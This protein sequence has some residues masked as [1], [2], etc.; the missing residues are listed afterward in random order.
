MGIRHRHDQMGFWDRDVGYPAYVMDR[1]AYAHTLLGQG[2]SSWEPLSK[3]LEDVAE[4]AATYAIAF[5]G[6][7]WARILGGCHDLGK[8]SAAFQRYLRL[9]ADA[10]DAGVEGNAGAH[11]DHSTFG[12]R[13]V[14]NRVGGW[15]G[16]L[17]AFAIAGHH[18]GLPN[19]VSSDGANERSTL[20]SRLDP[21]NSIPDVD[22]LNLNLPTLT[23]PWPT[24]TP[25]RAAWSL[26][27]FTRMLFSCLVDADRTCTEAFCSPDSARDRAV[28]RPSLSEL[29][30]A[31]TAHLEKL[32]ASAPASPVNACRADVLRGCLEA[33]IREP[34]FFSLQVPTGGGKTLSSLAFA[35]RHANFHPGMRRVIIAIPFTSIIE[36]TADVYRLALGEFAE[37]ALVEHHTNIAPVRDTR[38]NQLGTENWDAPLIVTTNV[39]LLESLFAARTTACRKLH[40]IAGSVIILDEAQTIPVDLLTPTLA[41]LRE[42]VEHSRCSVVLCTATQPALEQRQEFPQ[43]LSG[44]RQIIPS[45][46]RLFLRLNRVELKHAGRLTDTELVERLVASPQVLCIVNTRRHASELFDRLVLEAS[47]SSLHLST[48]MCGAHRRSVLSKI[49]ERLDNGQLC[50]IIST[51][52]IEAGVDIDLPVVYRASAGFDSIA[53]AA[54]RCNREGRLAKG[55]IYVFDADRDP[56]PGTL[57]EGAQCARELWHRYP[58]PLSPDAIREYFQR[59]Y[60]GRRDRWDAKNILRMFSLDR[61]R[62]T[63]RFQFRDAEEAYRLIEDSSIPILIPFDER[64]TGFLRSLASGQV[65]FIPQRYLQAYLVSVPARALRRLESDGIVQAHESGV[66]LLIREDAYSA[67]RGLRLEAIQ[68]DS[69]LWGV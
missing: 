68:L 43:G 54:G 23:F 56:P 29:E 42:L 64:A 33:A 15:K 1:I 60:W 6:Q 34:G 37:R 35:L 61:Y 66:Y 49:K 48:L 14:A 40:R 17:L 9:S 50:R 21:V 30:V 67:N 28:A 58:N 65:E 59:F 25:D 47:A 22:D 27:F 4:K 7:E 10:V 46:E 2:E 3:H 51:Q 18:T 11:V 38:A 31:L 52:L 24:P 13:F 62:N 20:T 36:Q 26:A 12:A 19:D 45:P 41:V 32:G 63:T 39:Q 55:L 44:V 8:R 16:R 57:R 69:T 53:Q 5:G